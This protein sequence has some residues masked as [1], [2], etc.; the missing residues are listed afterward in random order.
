ML[1][2]AIG[3]VLFSAGVAAAQSAAPAPTPAPS[4]ATQSTAET[5][6]A[7]ARANQSSQ[8]TQAASAASVG[9]VVVTATSRRL[10]LQHVPVAASA[11]TDQRRNLVGITTESDIV[12]FTPSMSLNGQFLSLRGVGRYTDELGTDPGVAVFVDGIYTPSPDYLN[13]PDFLS[14]RIEILRGPQGTLGG[15]N[16]IGGSVNVVSKRPT[17]TFH[18]EGRIGSDNYEAWYTDLSVS[19]PITDNL[20]FRIADA[21]AAEPSN[22]GNI[23][24]LDSSVHPGAGSSNLF[25]GQLE[26]KPTSNFDAWFR[27]QN[28][29]SDNAATY[30]VNPTQYPISTVSYCPTI[31]GAA[32]SCLGPNG[33][34]LFLAQTPPVGNP[35]V[36]NHNVVDVN[37]PGYIKLKNDWT[38]STQLTWSLPGA[39]LEYIG[40]YSQYDY[41]YLSD[42]DGTPSNAFAFPLISAVNTGFQAEK[43]YQNELELKSDSPG[44]LKWIVGAFQYWNH[45]DAPF[46]DEEPNNPSLANPIFAT[47][48]GAANCATTGPITSGPLAG[49]CPFAAPNPNRTTYS[50]VAHL[51]DESE[52]I[53][54]NVDYNITDTLKLT[55]GLRYNWDRKQGSVDY[56]EIFDTAGVFFD[57]PLFALDVTPAGANESATVSSS[58]W[59][60]KIGAEWQP[61]SSTLVY[62]S[63]SKGYKSAGMALLDISPIPVV[64]PE[65]LYDYEAGV[66]KTFGSQ[67]LINAD[68]YYYD[69]HNLQQF[70]TI[71]GA[72]N[73]FSSELVS[74]QKARTYGFELESVW[75]PTPDFQLT[76]NYSYLNAHFTQFTLPSGPIFDV[77]QLAPGCI[78]TGTAGPAGTPGQCV[79]VAH[80]NL[81]GNIIPQ[82]PANKVTINPVYTLNSLVGKFTFSATYAWIDQQYYGIFNNPGFLAPS[83]YNLDLRLLYQP[84]QGHVTFILFARNVTDQVQIVNYSTG[85]F[86]SGPA[87]LI[88]GAAAFPTSGQ[89]TYFINPPRTF[90]AELQVRF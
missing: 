28:F 89:V 74:A 45:Y 23:K 58:D 81:N 29:G 90:G 25:E 61:E 2:C 73:L 44:P 82:S 10:T 67:F 24:N 15:Q 68:V 75:S 13:Q 22:N 7:A 41:D 84:P 87:N 31:N 57:P 17:D 47:G 76:F 8:S 46:L 54:G 1:S 6:D 52:A 12:N 49:S 16:D 51:T 62:A 88:K 50:Q 37:V 63:V 55:G 39:T 30:G 69:Y 66:K 64:K 38:F 83:Y 26:W 78:G 34:S 59:T 56:R 14:D 11:Y 36:H 85:S 27:I 21:Y 3:A 42:L 60:G 40:G 53:Y 79:G 71:E 43:W 65:T 19:G 70:L 80:A 72:N 48:P 5:S 77:S 32:D 86:T 33:A 18:E 20:N 35:E 9:D 4:Q